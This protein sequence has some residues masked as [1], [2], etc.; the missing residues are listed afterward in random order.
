MQFHVER[1]K[2]GMGLNHRPLASLVPPHADIQGLC[3]TLLVQEL[4]RRQL[5]LRGWQRG[6]HAGSHLFIIALS[7]L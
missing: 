3:I 2:A 1:T 7:K 5:T 4:G 6:A